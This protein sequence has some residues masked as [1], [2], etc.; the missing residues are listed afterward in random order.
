MLQS[1]LWPIQSA[2]GFGEL[3]PGADAVILD[4]AHQFPD[5][6]AQFFGTRLGS[7]AVQ[8][9]LRDAELELT[10]AGLYDQAARQALEAIGAAVEAVGEALRGLGERV[11]WSALPEL[12][13][14]AAEQL[15][16][17]L[18]A[19]GARAA[20]PALEA[21]AVRQCGR[22]A[23]DAAARLR[24]L[25]AVDDASGLKWAEVSPRAFSLEFTP[26]EVAERLR[27]QA[28]ARPCA[29]IYTSATLAVGTDFTHFTGRV[30][31]ETARTLQIASPFDFGR[32]SRLYLPRGLP[33][34]SEPGHTR[35]VIEAALP[36]VRAAGGR[37]FLLFTSYRALGDGA[38]LLRERAGAD[39]P[40]PLLVQGDAPRDA[41]LTRFRELGNAV[42]LGTGSF[43]E[44]VDVRGPALSLVVIDKL[45]F[46]SPDDP[47]L[48][49]R[50]EGLKRAGRNG[51]V[52]HQIPQA[53]LALKQGVGRLIRDPTDF[54]VVLIADPRLRSR[55]YGRAFLASLPQMTVVLE[56]AEAVEFLR[57]H[58]GALAPTGTP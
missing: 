44:G 33:D 43:W 47:L 3:L 6:A 34:P 53:V 50:L 42:L 16:A 48:K 1:N 32:Q 15:A 18:E 39:C 22:R 45:P 36:L 5:V 52:E 55:G 20:E 37:S 13:G 11:E 29:W 56:E 35:A 28:E 49:A 9:L 46:A 17:A 10:R 40:F 58:L 21:A 38:R 19:F 31:A 23:T 30:G 54:G 51:F 14:E 57:H 27:A 7:R 2:E 25:L 26:F 8:A 4:E 12:A 24:Q 41:L